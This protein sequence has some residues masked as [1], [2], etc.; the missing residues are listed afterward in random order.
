[1]P[2]PS[3]TQ[4]S[5]RFIK[6]DKGQSYPVFDISG[7][8]NRIDGLKRT[9]NRGRED[10]IRVLGKEF[11]STLGKSSIKVDIESWDADRKPES[12]DLWYEITSTEYPGSEPA[13][14]LSRRTLF[15]ISEVFFGDNPSVLTD[16]SVE[17]RDISGTEMRLLARLSTAIMNLCGEITEHESQSWSLATPDEMPDQEAIWTRISVS[18]AEEEW[19]V[20]LFVGWPLTMFELERKFHEPNFTQDDVRDALMGMTVSAK[21]WVADLDTNLADIRRVKAGDIIEIQLPEETR[22][23]ASDIQVMAGKIFEES[24]HLGLKIN[25]N[26][27]IKE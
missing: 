16:K 4:K 15:S 13:M 9:L 19:E 21:A 25:E 26:L 7:E 10:M 20:E 11:R 3:G 18:E 1:M 23:F 14:A 8:A 27:G 17:S 6:A 22:V 2:S 24:D 12:S 5:R